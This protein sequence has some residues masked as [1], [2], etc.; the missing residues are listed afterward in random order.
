VNGFANLIDAAWWTADHAT[1]PQFA[2]AAFFIVAGLLAVGGFYKLRHPRTAAASAVRFGVAREPTRRLGYT[3]GVAELLT[4]TLLL[5]W[6]YQLALAGAAMALLLS[7]GFVVV[8]SRTLLN[9][10][11]FPCN[12][13]SDT[14]E[15]VSKATLLRALAMTVGVILGVVAMLR[16]SG[17][18]HVSP[19]STLGAAAI[20]LLATGIS[21][22]AHAGRRLLRAHRI[23]A[24]E[25]DWEWV[26][27]M[28][29]S[30][31]PVEQ[32]GS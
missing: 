22:T 16:S 1:H 14:N 9:G 28:H 8:I 4:A 24:A 17:S 18:L 10:V 2:L 5:S 21:L 7:G 20:A 23:L 29:R 12:C 32:K 6:P 11:S 25:I 19:E 3:L 31:H 26:V 27:A 13:L 15:P 30:N